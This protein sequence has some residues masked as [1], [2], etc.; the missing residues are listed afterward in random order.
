MFKKNGRL[1]GAHSSYSWCFSISPLNVQN[2]RKHDHHHDR[3]A[4]RVVEQRQRTTFF[5][6]INLTSKRLYSPV[7]KKSTLFNK[8]T[9]LVNLF[10]KL[11]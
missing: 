1:V 9:M 6:P 7:K 3:V 8:K 11:Y 5:S 2:E 4:G 10:L